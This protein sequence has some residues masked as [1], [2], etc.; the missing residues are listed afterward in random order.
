MAYIEA[1]LVTKSYKPLHL[2]PGML[3][4]N[5]LH[6]G[7]RREEVE[8]FA[9]NRVPFDEESFI[10]QNGHP[11][12]LYIMDD[13]GNILATPEQIGWFDEGDDVDELRDI[14]LKEINIILNDFD[15][16]IDLEI[17][18]VEEEDEE[19]YPVVYEGKVIIRY[20]QE[21][22]DDDEEEYT[23]NYC[24]HCNGTGEGMWDGSVCNVCG[25]SGII[26]DERDYEPD[27]N[28]PIH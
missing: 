11:I 6:H 9:L 13:E 23:D 27:D 28:E 17:H 12:Q 22:D 18:D 16:T 14:S 1:Q 2:E 8:I 5:K 4:V 7:T 26:E 25:G 3:F 20:V 10:L 24:S 21:Y 19:I 15:E